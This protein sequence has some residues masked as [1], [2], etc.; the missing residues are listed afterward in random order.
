MANPFWAVF[1]FFVVFFGSMF[2]L[3]FLWTPY[4][5]HCFYGLFFPEEGLP[6][7]DHQFIRF[8]NI[9]FGRGTA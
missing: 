2:L 6:F 4:S 7:F 5:P 9:F 8:L 3:S 1:F